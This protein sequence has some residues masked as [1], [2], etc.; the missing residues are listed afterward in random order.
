MSVASTTRRR[1]GG[2]GARARSCSSAGSAPAS[3]QHVDVGARRR[4]R[5]GRGS[6]GSRRCRAGTRARRRSSRPAPACTAPPTSA[7]RRSSRWRGA[8]SACRRDAS[9]RRCDDRRGASS[10]AEQAG[11]AGRVG[12]RRHRQDAQVGTQRRRHVERQGQAEVG[13]RLRSWTSSKITAATPGSS[14]SCLQPARQHA[15]GEHLDAGRRADAPLVAGLVADEP[16]DPPCR[17]GRPS[18]G[19]P[20]ASPAARLE[21]HDP[22]SPRHGS[23]SRASG[24][25]VVL[26]APGRGAD[27]GPA[28]GSSSAARD[29]VEDLD[30]REVGERRTWPATPRAG[31]PWNGPG[32]P[33][34]GMS[35]GCQAVGVGDRLGDRPPLRRV[36]PLGGGRHRAVD[37]DEHERRQR[38]EPERL[39]GGRGRGRR[40]RGTARRADRGTP[41]RPP[42]RR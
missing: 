20:P 32:S 42:R 30:D 18:G 26:P 28:A 19:P 4:R 38:L 33:T 21:H 12:G 24:T 23:S 27:D 13:V 40:T 11:E 14:G 5:A 9:A 2:D 6:A 15:L 36:P 31:V 22:P 35:G 41:W 17:R 10:A 7:S 37:A 1:P 3:G 8:A 16:A 25:T 34:T 29:R 39:D